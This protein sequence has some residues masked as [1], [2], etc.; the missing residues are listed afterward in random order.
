MQKSRPENVSQTAYKMTVKLIREETILSVDM[1]KQV[2]IS[3]SCSAGN[4]V[5]E[6]W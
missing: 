6:H 5:I 2:T 4:F 3:D 1:Y